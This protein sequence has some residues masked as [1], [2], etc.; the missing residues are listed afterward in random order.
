MWYTLDLAG[1]RK[2]RPLAGDLTLHAGSPADC[3]L[4]DELP[5]V[6]PAQGRARL[7]GGNDLWMV[8]EGGHPLFSCFIFRASAPA[9]AAPNGSLTLPDG[10]ACLEDSVTGA[11]ARGRGI[12]PAAWSA[13]ADILTGEG[14]HDLITKVAVENGPSRRAVVKAGFRPVA[15]MQFRRIGTLRRTHVYGLDDPVGEALA[16][17]LTTAR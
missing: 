12:A 7:A 11:A 17:T 1:E 6:S 10:T 16:R 5:T 8:L 14:L 4:L 9:I 15:L 2:R 13:I 3:D